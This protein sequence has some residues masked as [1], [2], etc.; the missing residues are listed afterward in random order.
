MHTVSSAL[1]NWNDIRLFLAVA[2]A[3]SMV[4][5]AR[6]ARTDQSTISRRINALQEKLGAKLFER[7]SKGMRLTETDKLVFS[8]AETMEE[9]AIDIERSSASVDGEMRGIVTISTTE[10]LGAYWLAPKLISVQRQ[11]PGL[12]INLDTTKIARDLSRHEADIA[13]RFNDPGAETNVARH[14]GRLQMRPFATQGYLRET[15]RPES[16]TERT[17]PGRAALSGAR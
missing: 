3:G 17:P 5:A 2:R 4:G 12:I 13:I 9:S 10:G 15:D 11:Y 14:V 8:F 7:Y 6:L 16:K 1:A